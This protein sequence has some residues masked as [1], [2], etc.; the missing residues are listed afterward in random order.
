MK[1]IEIILIALGFLGLTMILMHLPGGSFFTLTPFIILAF[2]Y[3][4]SGFALFNGIRFR[5]V[6]KKDSY[7]NIKPTRIVGA[8]GIGM[9]LNISILGVIFKFLHYPGASFLLLAGLVSTGIIATVSVIKKK[10]D[11]DGYYLN[12]LKRVAVFG[13]LCLILVVM[14]FRTWLIINHP[15]DP[16]YIEAVIKFRANPDDPELRKKVDEE[17]EKMV[18]KHKSDR[19]Q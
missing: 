2:I 13:T 10:K 3:M 5:R 15:K 16:E 7:H 11:K 12:I 9:A 4:Y 19:N 8:I 17:W 14:P 1:K 18:N 6:F